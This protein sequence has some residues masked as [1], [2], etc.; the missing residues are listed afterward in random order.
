MKIHKGV[1]IAAI[2]I[3]SI[4]LILFTVLVVHI[5]T[6]KPVQYDNAT[7]QISRIDFKE[8]IDSLKAK[9]IHRNMKSIAGVKNP[10]V[11]PEKNVVVY[12]HDIKTVNS[13]QVF[14]QL[15]AKGNYK[16]ERLVIPVDIASKGV[17]PVMDESS[18]KYKFSRGIKRIFN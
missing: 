13:E 6:A 9:E 7:M 8:P 1:K 16:A 3:V 12:Y 10:K 14:A 15:M 5:V 17:C 2:S 11:F 4:F 18:F